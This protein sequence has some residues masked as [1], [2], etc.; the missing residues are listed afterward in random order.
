MQLSWLL[1]RR[2]AIVSLK[3]NSIK[4]ATVRQLLIADEVTQ[5]GK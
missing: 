2:Y 1:T 4:F 5:S 3:M